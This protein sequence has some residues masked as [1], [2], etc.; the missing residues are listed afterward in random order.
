MSDAPNDEEDEKNSATTDCIE[1]SPSKSW[2][3]PEHVVCVVDAG[4]RSISFCGE[5]SVS[6]IVRLIDVGGVLIVM[7]GAVSNPASVTV[8]STVCFA[9]YPEPSSTIV[10]F[11]MSPTWHGVVSVS[12]STMYT[13][14]V[15]EG[16]EGPIT[17][18]IS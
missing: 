15:P 17:P 6:S 16:P 8:I 4:V 1:E 10:T 2:R 12:Q 3:T 11:R 13:F 5:V 14:G 9:T 7:F 18:K